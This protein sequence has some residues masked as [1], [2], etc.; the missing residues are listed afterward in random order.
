[1]VPRFAYH[2]RYDE[3][4]HRRQSP[5][6]MDFPDL[7]V[8]SGQG[9]IHIRNLFP[10]YIKSGLFGNSNRGTVIA[11]PDLQPLQIRGISKSGTIECFSRF[12]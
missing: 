12:V 3:P 2:S 7:L 9:D 11:L 5:D 4:Y 8:I 10:I 6:L 1:M